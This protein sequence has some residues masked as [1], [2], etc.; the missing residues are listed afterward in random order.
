MLTDYQQSKAKIGGILDELSG[1]L[2]ALDISRTALAV[3]DERKKKLDSDSFNLVVLGQ[4]KRGKTTFINALLGA[5]I[6]PTAIVPLTSIITRVSYGEKAGAQVRFIDGTTMQI[7]LDNLRKYV[8]ET[9]NPRNFKGVNMVEVNYPS[10]YLSQG[11]SLIDTPG[12]GSVFTHNT[13]I[14]Y[15]FIPMADAAIFVLSADPPISREEHQFLTDILKYVRKL[16]F[17]QNK[18]DVV[19]EDDR[20][21][22]L[23]FSKQVI[24]QETGLRDIHIYP[25]SAKLALD[26]LMNGIPAQIDASRLIEFKTELEK[27]LVEGRQATLLSA[28]AHIALQYVGE[29]EMKCELERLALE[30]PAADAEAKLAKL[31]DY[32]AGLRQDRMDL[33]YLLKGE[34]N[35]FNLRLE[36]ELAAFKEEAIMTLSGRVNEVL[37]EKS[38]LNVSHLASE[39]QEFLQATVKDQFSGLQSAKEQEIKEWL[40][41]TMERFEAKNN[42]LITDIRNLVAN[43]FNINPR[44]VCTASRLC[45]R[46]GLYFLTEL[47]KPFITFD[48]SWLMGFLPKK[49]A[50]RSLYKSCIDQIEELVDLNCGRL[51]SDFYTRVAQSLRD[52]KRLLGESLDLVMNE[53]VRTIEA[54]INQNRQGESVANQRRSELEHLKKHLVS[55]HEDLVPFDR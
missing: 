42:A 43:L 50:H 17:V 30:M 18:I 27:F 34:L 44:A 13:D 11:V 1:A 29:A 39:L 37:Q 52:F 22:S 40:G 4:Y 10:E 53:L 48:I 12:I 14:A 25:L 41:V 47:P 45:S 49:L 23:A 6:L 24:E 19:T 46:S 26:G 9:E 28:V 33:D 35:R 55:L 2:T 38:N 3:L 7:P 16:F 31:K 51:R 32:F 8:T 36:Q 54:A 21:Q 15:D 5:E 20:E